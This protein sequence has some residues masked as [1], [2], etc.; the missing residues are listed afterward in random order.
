M[1]DNLPGRTAW[2]TQQYN[3]DHGHRAASALGLRLI[4]DFIKNHPGPVPPPGSRIIVPVMDGTEAER[5]AVVDEW[6]AENHVQAEW[7]A[8]HHHYSAKLYFGPW[9]YAVY[10]MPDVPAAAEAAL[11]LAGAK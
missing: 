5:M 10:M 11:E 1:Q 9:T 2:E 4:A 8:G 7:S 6:A 3:R